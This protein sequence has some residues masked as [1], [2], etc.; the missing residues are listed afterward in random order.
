MELEENGFTII[1]N[2]IDDKT[3]S[4][5]IENLANLK[6]ERRDKS[7][8]GVRNLLNLSPKIKDFAESKVVR[9]IAEKYLGKDAKVVRAIYFDKTGQANWKVP[10]H[11]DLTVAVREKIETKGFTAWTIKAGIH[12]VQPPI[13]YLERMLTLRFHLDDAD[14]TNGALKV[15]AN[16]HKFGRLDA[17]K[18]QVV[19]SNKTAT[20]RAVKKGD[21]L[22]M[23]PL[24]V[25][26]S[27]AG[28]SPKHR[29]V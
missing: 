10:S 15:S 18:I 24:I 4:S 28:S 19:K 6:T 5:L 27:S 3:I 26:S 17:T 23:K 13:E 2:A 16:S 7:V 12:H 29:R 20:L 8:Y 22:L 11:Q 25:H 21:C 14:E 9:K 1:Q